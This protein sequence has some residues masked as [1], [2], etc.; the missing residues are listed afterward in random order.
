[1]SPRAHYLDLEYFRYNCL[2]KDLVLYK[3]TIEGLMYLRLYQ[4]DYNKTGTPDY[5]CAVSILYLNLLF[6]HN[7]SFRFH[8]FII[9]LNIFY[10]LLIIEVYFFKKIIYL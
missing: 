1:L 3:D 6:N 2:T 7:Q 8:I 4:D 9:D 10:F 5:K